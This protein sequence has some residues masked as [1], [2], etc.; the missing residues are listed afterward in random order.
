M[1]ND[2][3]TK[4]LLGFFFPCCP[5]LLAFAKPFYCC[6]LWNVT[7]KMFE[8]FKLSVSSAWLE[9]EDDAVVAR[10]NQ[11]IQDITGLTVDTAEL[12]QVQLT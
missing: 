3:K 9:A 11:R 8:Y 1:I 7:N 2:I 12:L 10:V 5:D 6:V 4:K